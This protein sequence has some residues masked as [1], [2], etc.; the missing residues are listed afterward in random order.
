MTLGTTDI[1]IGLV[2]DEINHAPNSLS[3]LVSDA[4]T[5]GTSGIAFDSAS[6][7]LIDDARPYWNIWSWGIPAEW[8]YSGGPMILRLPRNT[9][10]PKGYDYR[11]GGFRQYN[12]AAAAPQIAVSNV[13][14]VSGAGDVGVLMNVHE[15]HLPFDVTHIRVKI[16][17]GAA[18]QYI[19]IPVEDIDYT[20]GLIAGYTSSF[21]GI[22]TG[23]TTGTVTVYASNSSGTELADITEWLTLPNGSMGNSTINFTIAH[24]SSTGTLS[25]LV[26]YSEDPALVLTASISNPTG[27]GNISLAAGVATL[28][29]IVI[30]VAASSE[31]VSNFSFDLYLSQTGESDL[32]IGSYNGMAT[33]EGYP[34][35]YYLDEVTLSDAVAGGDTLGFVM[36]NLS[37]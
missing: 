37:Y 10:S 6:G 21:T 32:L 16:T 11:L 19:L 9:D 30:R 18:T 20:A 27:S 7:N 34:N 23:T 24:A 4:S 3:H 33:S 17:I 26:A 2:Q 8:D 35:D 12:H 31:T 36:T 14:A 29:G 13:T 15:W 25:R 28:S 1:S 5:G 22:G